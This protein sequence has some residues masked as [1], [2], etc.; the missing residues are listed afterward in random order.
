MRL[1]PTGVGVVVTIFWGA[2]LLVISLGA[3]KLLI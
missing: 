2:V 3:W 1:G